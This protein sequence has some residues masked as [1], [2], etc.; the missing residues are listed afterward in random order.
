MKPG[1]LHAIIALA[2]AGGVAGPGF[3]QTACS[4]A[5][6]FAFSFATAPAQTLS[7]TGS[8]SFSASNG[9]GGTRSFTVTF[10]TFNLTSSLVA[11]VQMPA[12]NTQVNDGSPASANNLVIGGR[13]S[14]RTANIANNNRVI[15]TT[16]SFATPVREFAI[17]AN[18]ID[19]ASNQYRDWIR[20]SGANGAATY[21]PSISSPF[22][23]NNGAG[24]KTNASSTFQLG[25]ST[26]PLTVSAED[27]LGNATSGNTAN[28]GTLTAVFTQPV[29]TVTLRYGNSGQSPGGSTT[30]QQA[31]GIQSVRFCPM[32]V[33]AI[34]KSSAPASSLGTDPNRFAIP[35]ADVDYTLTVTNSGGSTVDINS[36]LI[37]DILP[38]NVT[39]FN[40]DIDP[41]TAG[42]QNFVFAPGSSGLTLAAGNIAY[43]NNGGASYGYAPTPG[44]DGNIDALR[45]SPQ[46]TMAANS[47]FTIRFRTRVN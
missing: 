19:F 28:N 10:A 41:G 14:G 2:C 36:A 17:Q 44:Y 16:F 33:V 18:D 8:A 45:F 23:T 13:F 20:I 30:G 22:G 42:T 21:T 38:P 31:Y 47:S 39:F 34:A 40:G 4:A 15:V 24:P 26:T 3:A 37:A 1:P 46:G 29:T 11:G 9:L 25:A 32:P 43:S 12:I 35:G 27:A 5:N 7:Y 6:Q